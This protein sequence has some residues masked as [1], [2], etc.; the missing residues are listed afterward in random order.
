MFSYADALTK[1]LTIK[2]MYTT[3]NVDGFNIRKTACMYSNNEC[4]V[5]GKHISVDRN[6]AP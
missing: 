6:C 1:G 3:K 5:G 2:F 4:C